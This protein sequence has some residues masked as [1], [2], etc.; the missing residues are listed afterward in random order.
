MCIPFRC[1]CFLSDLLTSITERKTGSGDNRCAFLAISIQLEWSILTQEETN[2]HKTFHSFPS[3]SF[4]VLPLLDYF[5]F[6]S[7]SCIHSFVPQICVSFSYGYSYAC[8]CQ[9]QPETQQS[10]SDPLAMFGTIWCSQI[11][12]PSIGQQLT[13]D[14]AHYNDT[15]TVSN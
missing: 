3:V 14:S 13:K 10:L 11:T 1:Q 15:R 12:L 9:A 6:F 2:R 7:P 4:S 8:L 5:L